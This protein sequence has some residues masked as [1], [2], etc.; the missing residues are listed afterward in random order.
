M[1]PPSAPPPGWAGEFCGPCVVSLGLQTVAF[2]VSREHV[3]GT[4]NLLSSLAGCGSHP[5]IALLFGDMS[6]SSVAWFCCK[7]ACL[8][9]SLSKPALLSNRELTGVSHIFPTYNPLVG[10]TT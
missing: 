9:L 1:C 8:V 4:M 10:L 7:Q 5:T 2:R 6:H 3:L